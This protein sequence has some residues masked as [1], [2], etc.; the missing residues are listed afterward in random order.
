MGS[1]YGYLDGYGE[2]L[3]S[4]AVYIYYR[5]CNAYYRS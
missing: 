1:F 4:S 5:F 3:D 2:Y